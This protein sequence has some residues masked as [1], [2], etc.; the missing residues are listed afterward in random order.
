MLL[1][2]PSSRPRSPVGR[3]VIRWPDNRAGGLACL[4]ISFQAVAWA[5]KHVV[6]SCC[7]PGRDRDALSAL[8]ER[9]RARGA[10]SSCGPVAPRSCMRRVGARRPGP[11]PRGVV[12]TD[13]QSV[14]SRALVRPGQGTH[15]PH[16]TAGESDG[17]E[18]LCEQGKR[19]PTRPRR[20][21]GDG[22]GGVRRPGV[23]SPKGP[24]A[25]DLHF[26]AP[27]AR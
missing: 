11:Y 18:V 3:C 16:T 21:P 17:A 25:S 24:W 7:L 5:T 9:V 27:G 2:C 6:L 14:S 20:A 1:A 8:E 23:R 12:L 26:W 22:V 10:R 15:S 4:A 13:R 19:G